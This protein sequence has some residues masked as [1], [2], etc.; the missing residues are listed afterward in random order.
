MTIHTT[1]QDV[2]DMQAE[3][4]LLRRELAD[5]KSDAWIER[6]LACDGLWTG[7]H[8]DSRDVAKR[9]F[10]ETAREMEARR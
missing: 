4:A 10:L 7:I 2:A 5:I 3:I 6:V 8:P 1:Q 9:T